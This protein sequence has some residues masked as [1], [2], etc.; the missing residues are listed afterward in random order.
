MKYVK[1]SIK[2]AFTNQIIRK[3]KFSRNNI[4]KNTTNSFLI[5]VDYLRTHSQKLI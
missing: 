1:H 5:A 4:Y 3:E 2:D